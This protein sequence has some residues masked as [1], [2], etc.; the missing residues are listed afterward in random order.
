MYIRRRLF[1]PLC[2]DQVI[3]LVAANPVGR[4]LEG[5][6]SVVIRVTRSAALRFK[7]SWVT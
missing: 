6:K 7:V 4:R 3:M 2:H 1:R 5:A